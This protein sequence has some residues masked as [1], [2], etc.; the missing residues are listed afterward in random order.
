MLVPVILGRESLGDDIVKV[1][2]VR[3]DD[4]A[5]DIEE[6]ALGGGVGRSETTSLLEGVDQEPR[7]M[8]LAGEQAKR[9]HN[10]TDTR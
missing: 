2:V 5:S 3:E 4:V 10:A 9:Q 6:E 1:L 8:V 7:T